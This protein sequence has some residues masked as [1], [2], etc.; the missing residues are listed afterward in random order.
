MNA[1]LAK[2]VD[3]GRLLTQIG[4]LLNLQWTYAVR[5]PSPQSALPD[6]LAAVPPAEL[7]ELHRLARIG[8]MRDI[9]AWADRVSL[10]DPQYEPFS[11]HLRGLAKGYQSKAILLL[12]EHHLEARLAP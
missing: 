5:A 7:D 1:F 9:I 4:A 12:V 2:P 3:F 10:I 11:A 6:V 8:N